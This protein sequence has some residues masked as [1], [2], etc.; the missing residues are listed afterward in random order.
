MHVTAHEFVLWNSFTRA[1]QFARLS[2][3]CCPYRAKPGHV[4]PGSS[5]VLVVLCCGRPAVSM[6][7]NYNSVLNKSA[8]IW[9]LSCSLIVNNCWR[10]AHIWTS[11]LLLLFSSG[12]FCWRTKHNLSENIFRD[13]NHQFLYGT[14]R[15][16]ISI[17]GPKKFVLNQLKTLVSKLQC[18]W[19]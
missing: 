5:S 11:L 7:S 18:L 10:I 8:T 14:V 4:M 12:P 16:F 15:C 17:L 13:K 2:F 3:Q 6:A 1:F 9:L 19:I